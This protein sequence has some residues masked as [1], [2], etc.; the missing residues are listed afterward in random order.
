M[1]NAM[2]MLTVANPE[3]LNSPSGSTV[4][5]SSAAGLAA[6]LKTAVSGETIKL[7]AGNYGTV[8]ISNVKIS[9]NVNITSSNPNNPAVLTGLSISNS[10]GLT[11]TDLHLSVASSSNYYPVS[12][13][14]S[15]NIAFSGMD[16][17]GSLTNSISSGMMFQNDTNVSVVSSNFHQ[18]AN[19][20]VESGNS[21]MTVS[22]DIFTGLSADGVDNAQSSNVT[23][24]NNTFTDFTPQA[25]AHPD[26]IQFWTAGTTKASSDITISGNAISVGSGAATQGIFLTDQVGDLPYQNVSI[27]N[28]TITGELYNGIVVSHANNVE[29]SNNSVSS[30]NNY[31]SWIE[32]AEVTGGVLNGNSSSDYIMLANQSFTSSNN[33]M[34]GLLQ[35]NSV[36]SATSIQMTYKAPLSH[37][38]DVIGNARV[39]AQANGLGD[40]IYGNNAGDVLVGGAGSDTL[41]G[42]TGNDTITAGSGNDTLAGGKGIN[43]FVFGLTTT[44]DTIT[45]VNV[46]THDVIDLSAYIKAG[47]NP[48]L[49]N[50]GNNVIIELEPGHSITLLGVHADNLIHTSIGFSI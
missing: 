12:V 3:S 48:T 37:V 47:H 38:L 42:G 7:A 24:S 20:I 39:T 33:S 23:I 32:L 14:G 31:T 4:S 15:S 17:A 41:V 19:G 2:T 26:A 30:G 18:L 8:S 27:N 21:G 9:G 11:F 16:V 45:D 44:T 50:S 46:G 1:E 10:S 28:N 22:D 13:R 40:Y 5:V 6:A 25:G 49:V 36:T 29:I 35:T 43:T 34:S